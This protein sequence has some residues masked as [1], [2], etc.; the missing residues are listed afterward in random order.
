MVIHSIIR[1]IMSLDPYSYHRIWVKVTSSTRRGRRFAFVRSTGD[2]SKPC[3]AVEP[4]LHQFLSVAQLY[5]SILFLV[6]QDPVGDSQIC[7]GA[8]QKRCDQPSVG[9][10]VCGS[11]YLS[12]ASY[13]IPHAISSASV[14]T[15]QVLRR[16]SAYHDVCP[17]VLLNP[18]GFGAQSFCHQKPLRKR[19]ENG[20]R[21][22]AV[23]E[24]FYATSSQRL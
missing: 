2:G 1:R 21:F 7:G 8:Q 6:A 18:F 19:V 16:H 22:A 10:R 23:A 9:G 14:F 11:P 20:P 5:L 17:R 15:C 4:Q 24:A 3:T 12:I 13:W